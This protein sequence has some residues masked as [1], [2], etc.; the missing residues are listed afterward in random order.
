MMTK[1]KRNK[2]KK[3]MTQKGLLQQDILV[4]ILMRLYI[5]Y[6]KMFG[7]CHIYTRHR[8]PYFE[9]KTKKKLFVT[10][11]LFVVYHPIAYTDLC[12]VLLYDYVC[13]NQTGISE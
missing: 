2:I 11:F 3:K 8:H 4:I 5:S 6:N 1:E 10:H 7:H 13:T 9:K 12:H